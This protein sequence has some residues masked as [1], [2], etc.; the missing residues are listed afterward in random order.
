[1][2]KEAEAWLRSQRA[3]HFAGTITYTRDGVSN[4]NVQATKAETRYETDDGAV[5]MNAKA[6][7]WLID[8]TELTLDGSQVQP[9]PG[10]QITDGTTTY[11]VAALGGESRAWIYHGRD[12]LTYRIHTVQT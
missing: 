4:A 12:N 1:L 2:F 8:N 3:E 11:L 7:D 9:Q 6:V 5:I 10:D